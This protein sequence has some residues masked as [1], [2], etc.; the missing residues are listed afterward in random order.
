VQIKIKEF[1]KI[2][3]ISMSCLAT[4]SS[5]KDTE[6]VEFNYEEVQAFMQKEIASTE[7]FL[8]KITAAISDEDDDPAT[9]PV[10]NGE[11]HESGSDSRDGSDISS[12]DEG[13]SIC[14]NPSWQGA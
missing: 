6:N 9:A 8:A 1:E 3:K 10:G 11:T 13:V 5:M 2:R 7:Q 12:S 14:L 4:P